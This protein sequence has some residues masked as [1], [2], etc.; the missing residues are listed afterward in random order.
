MTQNR[1]ELIGWAII[2]VALLVEIPRFMVV[3]WRI[4]GVPSEPAEIVGILTGIGMGIIL[5]GGVAYVFEAWRVERKGTRSWKILLG[6]F[7]GFLLAEGVMLTPYVSAGISG[8]T[9]SNTVGQGTFNFVW[10]VV[11]A[12]SPLAVVAGTAYAMQS[13]D[14]Q[15]SV[16]SVQP[17]VQQQP[18]TPAP[19]PSSLV[20]SGHNR[21][22]LDVA[23]RKRLNGKASRMD[24][25]LDFFERNPNA[26]LN[27]A[28]QYVER[29]KST[30]SNYLNELEQTGK[31]RRTDDGRVIV[32]NGREV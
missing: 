29:A 5:P 27:E 23:N 12:L 13:F 28:G 8:V 7:V 24:A 22:D 32:L 15:P 4:E 18:N 20:E 25:L 17:T 2:L 30:V 19:A 26:T 1:K 21:G 31:V 10:S 11:T 14:V 9:M 16:Q 3:N 6:F